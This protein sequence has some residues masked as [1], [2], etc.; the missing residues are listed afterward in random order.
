MKKIVF[1]LAFIAGSSTIYA[2]KIDDIDDLLRTP[3]YDMLKAKTMIDNY[4]ANPKNAD[5]SDGWFYKAVIYN[6]ISKKDSLKSACPDCLDQ[7][8]VALKKYQDLDSKNVLLLIKPYIN[9]FSLYGNYFD[10]AIN[11]F[12][13]NNFSGAYTN[14]DKANAVEEYIKSKNIEAANGFKFPALDTS[15]VINAALAARQSKDSANAAAYY[16]KITDAE[17][18]DQQYLI[19]YEFQ[20]EYYFN[21][22]DNAS[23][24]A[25]L[26]KG[27]KLFPSDAYWDAIDIDRV[28]AKGGKTEVF[29]KYDEIL[30]ANPTNY[31]VGYNYAA[32]LYNYIFSNDDKKI[33]TTPYKDKLHEVVKN[34][35]A[36]KSN[37]DDNLLMAKYLYNSSFDYGDSARMV[38]GVKP[39]DVKRRKDFN[40]L[41]T[42]QM[43]EALPYAQA[44]AAY[45]E[46]LPTLKPVDKGNYR[47]TLSI[48]QSIYEVKKDAAKAAEYDKKMKS[49]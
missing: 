49:L 33:N 45:Y 39:A 46:G 9:F 12:N 19:A 23:L 14:F 28:A 35:I 22:G 44:A 11:D 36:L 5:K 43:N 20:A 1:L 24:D 25:V 40:D 34:L 31:A 6:E 8:F 13:G 27:R 2:Q 41:S 32:E 42:A 17:L 7:A 18:A 48:L 38:K 37:G 47:A 4:Q 21:K 10:R 3:G 16:K 29:K 15:L 26:A 30:A